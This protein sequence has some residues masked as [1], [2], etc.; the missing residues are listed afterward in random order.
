MKKMPTSILCGIV[1]ILVTVLLYFT[2]IGNIFAQI[3]CFIT[4]IGVVLAEIVVTILAYRSQGEPRKV[5]ATVTTSFMIPISILL[6]IVYIV[7]F[8]KGYGSYL[9]YYFSSFAILLL[10]SAIIWKFANNRK[11][12]NERNTK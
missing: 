11:N 5:A 1:A 8:P 10:I 6:S 2:I 3:I 9:G 12:D 4:L 7:N